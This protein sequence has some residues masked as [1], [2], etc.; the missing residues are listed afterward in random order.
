MNTSVSNN[1]CNDGVPTPEGVARSLKSNIYCLT[2][3]MALQSLVQK[4]RALLRAKEHPVAAHFCAGYSIQAEFST[5]MSVRLGLRNTS[6]DVPALVIQF[7]NGRFKREKWPQFQFVLALALTDTC[8]KTALLS[9]VT[10][11]CGERN[12]AFSFSKK[13]K[14]KR[15]ER[16]GSKICSSFC[17][18]V[19]KKLVDW[20]MPCH[21]VLFSTTPSPITA[22]SN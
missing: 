2:L 13:R 17:E 9:R 4:A 18:R 22:V 21:R 3:P 10:R 5:L 11:T 8:S 20:M 16:F 14:K 19:R 15:E 12:L 7:C 1:I 6:A